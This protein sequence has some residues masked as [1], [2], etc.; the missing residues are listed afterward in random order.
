[1]PDETNPPGASNFGS[2]PSS[3][4]PGSEKIED[5]KAHARQAAEDLRAAAQ[6]KA[7]HLRGRAEEYYGQARERAENYYGEARHR[8]R[9]FQEEGEAYIRDN[10]IQ[11]VL[12]AVGAGF[13]L[14]LLFRR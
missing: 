9:T 7:E 4:K 3:G 5:A 13:I 11:A 2:E 10:P 8:A 6:A 12:T 1:M 14:G